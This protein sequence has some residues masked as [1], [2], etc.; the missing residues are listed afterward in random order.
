MAG[1]GTYWQKAT[2]SPSA[3][4]ADGEQQAAVAG[5]EEPA[6]GHREAP[7]DLAPAA[8]GHAAPAAARASAGSTSAASWNSMV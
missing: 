6:E 8:L 3:S 7:L 1:A 4:E 5:V 2:G